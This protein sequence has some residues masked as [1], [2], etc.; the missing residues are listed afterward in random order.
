MCGLCSWKP[1]SLE[2]AKAARQDCKADS[3]LP[4]RFRSARLSSF[5]KHLSTNTEPL[6]MKTSDEIEQA[7][8]HS[9]LRRSP[10]GC[11]CFGARK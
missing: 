3:P 5:Y 4:A 2:E 6:L 11:R 10:L 1:P 8:R 7:N 9:M